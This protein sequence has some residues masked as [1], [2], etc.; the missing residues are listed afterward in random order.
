MALL[1][2]EVDMESDYDS[3]STSISSI[4]LHVLRYFSFFFLS[5]TSK[6]PEGLSVGSSKPANV[7]SKAARI[8]VG[9]EGARHQIL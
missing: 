6:N 2:I 1:L 4:F 9:G 3:M 8:G 5:Y 7:D